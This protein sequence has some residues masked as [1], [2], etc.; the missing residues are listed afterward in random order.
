[1]RRE[2]SANASTLLEIGRVDRTAEGA[3]FCVGR[4][5]RPGGKRL[6]QQVAT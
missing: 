1:M 2:D 5:L 3:G 4:R 6:N